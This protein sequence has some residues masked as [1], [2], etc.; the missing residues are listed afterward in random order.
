MKAAACV[1]FFVRPLFKCG[2][3]AMFWF[4]K[5][6]KAVWRDLTCTVKE[7]LE[8]V[9]VT[10]LFQN[11]NRHF[12]IHK[13]VEF[14]TPWTILGRQF[15]AA[16]SICVRFM[17]NVRVSGKCAFLSSA[18]FIHDFTVFPS[19]GAFLRN[20]LWTLHFKK[21]ECVNLAKYLHFR[22]DSIILRRLRHSSGFIFCF[23]LSF[24]I[25]RR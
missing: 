23:V 7:K 15:Q 17:C 20:K 3:Y 22:F 9:N 4:S 10:K 21:L 5:P 8:V 19:L 6:A 2:L 14:P 18:A 24:R 12:G 16:S 25:C 11:V 13:V 1:Q